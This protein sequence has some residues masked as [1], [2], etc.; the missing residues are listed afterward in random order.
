MVV[1]FKFWGEKKVCLFCTHTMWVIYAQTQS[2][3]VC[4]FHENLEISWEIW[5][6]YNEKY[7]YICIVREPVTLIMLLLWEQSLLISCWPRPPVL[8]DWSRWDRL[9]LG[10]S[11]EA[12]VVNR[13]LSNLLFCFWLLGSPP[14]P[15]FNYR[16]KNWLSQ[17]SELLFKIALDQVCCYKYA[18]E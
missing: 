16:H 14:H 5:A 7:W 8:P 2:E 1:S 10:K 4:V 15:T 9:F 17:T 13:S 12:H 6:V 3:M 18:N 11:R